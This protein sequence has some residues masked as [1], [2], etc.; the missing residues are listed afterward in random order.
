MKLVE[1]HKKGNLLSVFGTGTAAIISSVGWLTYND[2]TMEINGGEPADLDL[3][4]FEEITSIHYG[5]KEDIHNW[6]M[7]VEKKGVEVS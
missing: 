6:L 3:K 1:A 2:K 4:L 5:L 7:T